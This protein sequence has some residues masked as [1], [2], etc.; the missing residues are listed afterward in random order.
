MLRALLDLRIRYLSEELLVAVATGIA[1]LVEREHLRTDY[2]LPPID[3]PRI[4]ATVSEK[5]K[6]VIKN[7]IKQQAT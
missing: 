3:D 7:R 4:L 2:I 1:S 5:L 6:Q